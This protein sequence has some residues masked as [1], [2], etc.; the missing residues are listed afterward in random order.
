MTQVV[1]ETFTRYD[2]TV[3]TT[4]NFLH[5]KHDFFGSFCILV[6][7]LFVCFFK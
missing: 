7:C 3:T 2:S 4:I 6:F 5:M 1:S